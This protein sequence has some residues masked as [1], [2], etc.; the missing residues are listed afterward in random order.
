M[1]KAATS[2][3]HLAIDYLAMI[4]LLLVVPC[5]HCGTHSRCVS[6]P[7]AHLECCAVMTEKNRERGERA[8]GTESDER[9][10][11]APCRK[12]GSVKKLPLPFV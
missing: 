11:H 10:E 9:Y 7:F 6:K 3:A 5:L 1:Q 12:I 8:R 4:V 2:N